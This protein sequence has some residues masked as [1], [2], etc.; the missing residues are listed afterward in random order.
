MTPKQTGIPWTRHARMR[1]DARHLPP[2]VV[3][4]VLDFGRRVHLRH[5]DCLVV[6][7]REVKR[8]GAAGR[9]IRRAEGVHLILSPSGR[10]V[11]LYRDRSLAT[12]RR[13]AREAHPRG[14][15]D[16]REHR[17]GGAR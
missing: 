3:E 12:V 13:L 7:R 4:D 17:R 10:L 9:D 15:R 16:H 1:S 2:A 5:V 11:T 8:A 14:L 6:G